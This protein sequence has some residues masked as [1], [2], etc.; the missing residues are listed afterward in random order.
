MSNRA[1]IEPT[2]FR[3]V[4]TGDVSLGVLVW[5]DFGCGYTNH[6][7][8]IPDDDLDILHKVLSEHISEEVDGVIRLVFEQEKGLYIG[9][10][11]YEWEDVKRVWDSSEE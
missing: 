3:N 2:E 4:R 9:N 6:W 10:V 5:D 7:E 11:Y 1:Y 8:S